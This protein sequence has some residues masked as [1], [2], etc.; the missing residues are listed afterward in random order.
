MNYK[1]EQVWGKGGKLGFGTCPHKQ[2]N[3]FIVSGGLRLQVESIRGQ[4]LVLLPLESKN[5]SEVLGFRGKLAYC[6]YLFI[7]STN[8]DAPLARNWE[9][10]ETQ[11]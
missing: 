3:C 4:V 2:I 10:L 6:M 11:K 1:K 5:S 9:A 8:H 7:Y